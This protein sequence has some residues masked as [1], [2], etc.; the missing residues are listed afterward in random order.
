MVRVGG[1]VIQ[2]YEEYH[3]EALNI[4]SDEEYYVIIKNDPFKNIQEELN[5]L[6]TQATGDGILTKN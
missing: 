2:D 5:M 6:L 4:L 3:G 1:V